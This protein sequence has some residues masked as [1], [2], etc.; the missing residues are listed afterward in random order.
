[1]KP[2]TPIQ[3]EVERLSQ[4]LPP[5]SDEDM[6]WAWENIYHHHVY[7][8]KKEAT[9][10]TCGHTWEN[11]TDR[12]TLLHSVGGYTCPNCGRSLTPLQSRQRILTDVQYISK[13]TTHAKYQVVRQFYVRRTC[14][15]RSEASFISVEVVQHWIRE[16]GQYVV[17]AM[18][19]NAF[20]SYFNSDG[21]W[22]MGSEL[23]IR[24][25][26]DKYYVHAKHTFPKVRVMKVIRR[27]GYK[28]SFHDWHP[29]Y[30][31]ELILTKPKAETLLK[32]KQY[33]LFN[34]FDRNEHQI[35]EYW[36]QIKIC[37]RNNYKIKDPGIWFDHLELLQEFGRDIHSPVFICSPT[38]KQDHQRLVAKKQRIEDRDRAEQERKIARENEA[39]RKAKKSLFKLSF[40]DGGITIVVLKSVKD[41]KAEGEALQHCVYA[42]NYHKRDNS[43]IMSA[44]KDGQRIAT[45]ELSL[46]EMKVLQCRGYENKETPYDKKI[47]SLVN[48]NIPVISKA[49]QQKQ[50]S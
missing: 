50:V 45:I 37:M 6:L 18:L 36:Q 14:R 24:H 15:A 5:I 30:F 39:F 22:C 40:A 35:E 49:L 38:L 8:T 34:N 7:K 31:C 17:R 19:Q 21:A 2:K 12:T 11:N 28:G 43:L 48:R 10:F 47:I 29:S 44:R 27:N 33:A 46:K 42:N 26:Q 1:M 4:S 23:E 13:I 25:A 41:F 16:D 9:C 32:A 20:G 3:K